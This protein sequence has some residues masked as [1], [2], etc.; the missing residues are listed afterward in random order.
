MC[1]SRF[2][3]GKALIM[4]LLVV[5][6]ASMQGKVLVTPLGQ[7]D[8]PFKD[9]ILTTVP[10]NVELEASSVRFGPGGAF[11]AY[12]G[13]KGGKRSIYIGTKNGRPWM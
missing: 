12:A 5:S 9:R 3:I 7:D 10:A 1:S 2:R 11:V 4:Y 6:Q 8:D 13:S